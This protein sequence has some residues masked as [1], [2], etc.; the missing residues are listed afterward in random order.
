MNTHKII[1]NIIGDYNSKNRAVTKNVMVKRIVAT[2]NAYR[3]DDFKNSSK[4][5]VRGTYEYLKAGPKRK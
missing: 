5:D 2:D 4:M 1:N 3:I